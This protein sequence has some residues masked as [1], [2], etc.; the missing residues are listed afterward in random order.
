MA[1]QLNAYKKREESFNDCELNQWNLLCVVATNNNNNKTNKNKRENRTK[2]DLDTEQG[3]EA[4][5]S[6]S[7]FSK[8]EL[9][10]RSVAGCLVEMS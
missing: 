9:M 7:D 6:F 5:N 4:S 2:E 10:Q 1:L 8:L 3:R